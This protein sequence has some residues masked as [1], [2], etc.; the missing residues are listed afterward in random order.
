MERLDGVPIRQHAIPLM[1]MFAEAHGMTWGE[2][3]RILESK[4]LKQVRASFGI[5]TYT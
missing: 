1:T 3:K 5:C 4:D 2:L